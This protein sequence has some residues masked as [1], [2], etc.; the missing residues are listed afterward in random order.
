M[1]AKTPYALIVEGTIEKKTLSELKLTQKW[2]FQELQKKGLNLADIFFA[3]V[4]A[5]H[6]LH[7]SLRHSN[8]KL[9]PEIK[10]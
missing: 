7:V 3:S 1:I 8:K 10:H 6:E 2:L 5:N 4:N 9:K